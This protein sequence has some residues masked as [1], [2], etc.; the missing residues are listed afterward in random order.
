VL[1]T[2]VPIDLDLDADRLVED[3]AL[4]EASDWKTREFQ[5]RRKFRGVYADAS[6]VAAAGEVDSGR[7]VAMADYRPTALFKRCAYFQEVVSKFK[8]RLRHVRLSSMNPRSRLATHIDK[9]G[10]YSDDPVRFHIPI[11]TNEGSILTVAGET[12]HPQVGECWYFDTHVLHSAANRGATDRVHLII[13]CEVSEEINTLVGFDVLA[14]R[15]RNVLALH[16]H[17]K[18]HLKREE[19]W[20]RLAAETG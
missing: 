14:Y 11:V 12:I 9:Y 16:Q 8:G 7:A 6:L 13:D 3:F 15:K 4:V 10:K 2:H 20:S 5:D 17:S 1:I 19:R 18:A